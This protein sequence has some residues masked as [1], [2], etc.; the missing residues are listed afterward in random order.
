MLQ[1]FGKKS[2]KKSKQ[3]VANKKLQER[4]AFLE[5]ELQYA[6]HD[7]EG[8]KT[9]NERLNQR[10]SVQEQLM[11]TSQTRIEK[12]EEKFIALCMQSSNY[13][14]YLNE[15]NTTDAQ[16]E[17]KQFVDTQKK[18]DY[19]GMQEMGIFSDEMPVV[20]I[21]HGSDQSQTA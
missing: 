6:Q 13:A 12:Y 21:P 15:R 16:R 18:K 2:K 9:E 8:L 19:D 11:Q 14:M 10:L 1:G 4:V 3:T 5:R 20:D 17:L 7:N